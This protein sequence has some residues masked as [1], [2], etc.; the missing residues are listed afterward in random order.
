MHSKKIQ[1]QFMI[2]MC[3]IRIHIPLQTQHVI[4]TKA[5][6]FCEESLHTFRFRNM[7]LIKFN[8]G[9]NYYVAI[10]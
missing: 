5:K 9:R 10:F 7:Q 3:E 1:R 6:T 4:S 2:M 8:W